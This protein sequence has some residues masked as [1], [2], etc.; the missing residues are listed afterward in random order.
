MNT[1]EILGVIIGPAVDACSVAIAVGA[2]LNRPTLRQYFRISFH[3]GLFQFMMPLIGCFLGLMIQQFTNDYGRWV[4]MI[5]MTL[6][7]V[8]MIRE[9][10]S[11]GNDSHL[12]DPSRGASLILLSLATSIDALVVGISLGILG[13]PIVT[14]C[15]LI[16][17]VTALLSLLGMSLGK[18]TGSIFGGRMPMVGG[19]ILIAIGIMI[20]L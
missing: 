12:S 16:G 10:F 15:I 8:N 4:A 18:Q 9:A 20:A 13:G 6:V 11:K 3:F 14:T 5:L 7:G 17:T 19:F 1:V 2:I